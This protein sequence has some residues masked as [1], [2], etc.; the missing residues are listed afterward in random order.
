MLAGYL[1]DFQ[2][3]LF[4]FSGCRVQVVEREMN[5]KHGKV[6]LCQKSSQV[7]LKN[8]DCDFS[9]LNFLPTSLGPTSV[10]ELHKIALKELSRALWN[11]KN[12]M[13]DFPGS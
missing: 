8:R 3:T 11:S 2:S 1:Q 7:N 5:A 12:S 10:V 6:T 9:S 4:V 13:F